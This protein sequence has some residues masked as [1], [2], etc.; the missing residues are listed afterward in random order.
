MI[1][2]E[3][4]AS[5]EVK[6][7]YITIFFFL[8][9]KIIIH[10]VYKE[11]DLKIQYNAMWYN[12]LCASDAEW[13]TTEIQLCAIHNNYINHY[14]SNIYLENKQLNVFSRKVRRKKDVFVLKLE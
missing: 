14:L 1:K 5:R 4:N 9:W 12:E 13:K 8:F 6:N 3:N 10:D 2:I 7:C 11:Y